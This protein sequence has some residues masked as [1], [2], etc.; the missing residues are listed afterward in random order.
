MDTVIPVNDQQRAGNNAFTRLNGV[1]IACM[2]TLKKMKEEEPLKRVSIYNVIATCTQVE[3]KLIVNHKYLY[4]RDE[5]IEAEEVNVRNNP[6]DEAA[7]QNLE[8]LKQSM[9]IRNIGNANIDTEI[10]FE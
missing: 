2:E 8:A 6:D 5:K 10:T 3:A 1:K 7:K 9:I 4:I